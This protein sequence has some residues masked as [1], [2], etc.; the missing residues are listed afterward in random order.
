MHVWFERTRMVLQLLRAGVAVLHSDADALWFKNPV[1]AISPHTPTHP[2][3]PAHMR[4]RTTFALR[5]VV[6]GLH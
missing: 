4:A 6:V 1:R 2:T 5:A 3:T